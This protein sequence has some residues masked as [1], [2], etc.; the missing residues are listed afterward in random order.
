MT[1]QVGGLHGQRLAA[2][3]AGHTHELL[4]LLAGAVV[5]LAV[6]V[7]L[8]LGVGGD[9]A[10][11]VAQDDL[12]GG[13]GDDVLSMTGVLPPPPGASTTKVGTQKPEVWPRRPSM[14]SMPC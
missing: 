14:I 4:L 2:L 5:A 13:L 3:Q 6:G 12:L 10:L 9:D 1:L 7:V 11:V 8:G